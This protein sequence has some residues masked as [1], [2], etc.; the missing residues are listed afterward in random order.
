MYFNTFYGDLDFAFRHKAPLVHLGQTS[1][2][3]KAR[4][5]STPRGVFGF[6]RA[7]NGLLNIAFRRFARHV[8]PKIEHPEAR[9]VFK[10]QT[11]QEG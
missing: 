2:H 10:D 6:V 3:F 7:T 1:D 9:D 8:F 11:G 5:G 4:L